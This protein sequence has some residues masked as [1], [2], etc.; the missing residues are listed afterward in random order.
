MSSNEDGN[1][2]GIDV[3]SKELVVAARDSG[4]GLHE[5][6][7]GN[8]RSGHEVLH[9]WL[10]RLGVARVCVEA[11]GIYSLDL[12]LSLKAAE[13]IEVMVANP[14]AV[15]AFGQA[16]LA[17]NKT[18][19]ADAQVILAFAERMPF[20]PWTSPSEAALTVRAITR[21]ILALTKEQTAEK[22]Q[23]HAAK[24]TRTTPAVVLEDLA[25]GVRC[26]GARIEHLEQ[27]ALGL[28]R[29][30]PKQRKRLELLVTVT[31]IAERSALRILAELVTLPDDMSAKQW[32][33]HAGLDP[34]K[35]QSG[36]SLDKP[37]RISKKGNRYLRAA[38][39]MS[40]LSAIR[41]EPP[42]AEYSRRLVARGKKPMQAN[43]AVMRKLL[44]AIH[45][46]FRS[47]A[48]FDS[49]LCFPT[50][51]SPHEIGPGLSSA[52][53]ASQVGFADAAST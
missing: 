45:G 6:V 25:E 17:R 48:A 33:A 35:V 50:P 19:R 34:R 36:T 40:A 47:G 8:S 41:H 28:L 46:M 31:G 5:R 42:I 11:S 18:D 49:S 43:V 27:E 7:F 30:E 15:K 10:L 3:G 9:R 26:L 14:R 24:R 4:G 44:H 29:S 20:K 37:T 32:V 2:A 22:N 16:M 53:S 23:Y 38:L 39:Y 13:G 1:A 21:R 52:R 12:S 51:R